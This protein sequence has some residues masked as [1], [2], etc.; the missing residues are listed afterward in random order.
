MPRQL[1]TVQTGNRTAAQPVTFATVTVADGAEF[2]MPGTAFKPVIL[3]KNAGAAPA[4]LR[5]PFA[6]TI[7]GVAP[8]A[9][10]LT[11]P[12]SATATYV[13]GAYGDE[14]KQSNGKVNIDVV[15]GSLEIAIVTP[16]AV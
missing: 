16:G 8:S 3:V 7:D 10:T 9:R 2:V 12:N 6:R 5:V 14:Y 1:I 13:A 4:D 11:C 15:G